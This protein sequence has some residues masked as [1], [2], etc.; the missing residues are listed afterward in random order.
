MN[1]EIKFRG[2]ELEFGYF[3][4]GSLIS[5]NP[6]P[7]IQSTEIDDMDYDY[8]RCEVE[9][10]TVGQFTG[11]LDKNGNEVYEG[12]ILINNM[13]VKKKV[14]FN[15]ENACF[16]VKFLSGGG[17]IDPLDYFLE[18]GGEIVGNIHENPAEKE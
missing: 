7:E 13:G 6:I 2:K 4:Y 10:E 1:R 5:Y 12:D 11:L 8:A 16:K 9:P 3:V 15:V 17:Y 18:R 14:F